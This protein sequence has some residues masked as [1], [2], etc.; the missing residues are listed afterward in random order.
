MVSA[1]APRHLHS[2]FSY[3]DTSR[4]HRFR[5]TVQDQLALVGPSGRY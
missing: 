2:R 3:F 5:S 1:V 4:R